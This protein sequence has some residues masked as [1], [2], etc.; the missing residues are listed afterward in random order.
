MLAN[1]A[2]ADI[3][4]ADA[5]DATAVTTG[6]DVI[7]AIAGITVNDVDDATGYSDYASITSSDSSTSTSSS[8]SNADVAILVHYLRLHLLHGSTPGPRPAE[9]LNSWWGPKG[10]AREMPP[11]RTSVRGGAKGSTSERAFL[12]GLILYQP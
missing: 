2:T 11:P 10:G 8:D 6:N 9:G 1:D 4:A 5:T 3:T 12:E 7:N